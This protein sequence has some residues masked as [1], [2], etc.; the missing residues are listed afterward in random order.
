MVLN[1]IDKPLRMLDTHPHRKR[2]CLD[3]N[4]VIYQRLIDVMRRMAC[5]QYD[6]RTGN[7]LPTKTHTDDPPVM[8]FETG[9]PTSEMDFAAGV[10]DR[11]AD[12]R[13]DTRKFIRTDMGMRF[14][15]DLF[16][17]TVKDERL[18]R[19]VV[20][21]P[22]FAAGEEFPVGKGAGAARSE[23]I[24][25]IGIHRAV[26]VDAC[27]VPFPFGDTFPAFKDDGFIAPLDKPQCG[28]KPCGA[29]PYDN[30]LRASAHLRIIEMHGRRGRFVI[31]IEFECQVDP[32]LPLPC[33]DRAFDNPQQGDVPFID[34]CGTGRQRRIPAHIGRHFGPEGQNNGFR[35]GL[36][37]TLM[38]QRYDFFSIRIQSGCFWQGATIGHRFAGHEE[39]T[40]TT[41]G[42]IRMEAAE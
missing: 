34:A 3:T 2:F 35:H 26:P 32:G 28:K 6:G 16:G 39:G 21:A 18:Q 37:Q 38:K 5:R 9:H 11:P 22:F 40:D 29:G 20:V 10:L 25:R 12:I 13:N 4:P 15:E 19:L 7:S 1:R 31:G 24:I 33:I 14:I 30:H 8:E 17:G 23:S 41:H 36:K 27:H 42:K